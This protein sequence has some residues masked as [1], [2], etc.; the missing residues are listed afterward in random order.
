MDHM[1]INLKHVLNEEQSLEMHEINSR[2]GTLTSFDWEVSHTVNFR[3]TC[4]HNS[5]M[6]GE[7]IKDTHAITACL[8]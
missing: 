7:R 4:F 5:T 6:D 8:Y 2:Y 3:L 1:V